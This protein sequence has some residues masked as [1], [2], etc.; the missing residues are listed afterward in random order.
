MAGLTT[1]GF[2][3]KTAA[4]VLAELADA[5]RAS[6]ALGPDWDTSAESPTGQLNGSIATR[7]GSLWELAKLVYDSRDPRAA[8]FAA[9]DSVS[10]LT[11]TAREAA[12]KGTVTLTL[13]VAAGRTIPAG[14][15]AHVVGAPTNRWVTKAA[16]VNST[17]STASVSV[18]AEAEI[19]GAV[20]S[21][22]ASYAANAGTITAIAT[23]V[24]GW[25]SV[26]NASDAVT[27]TAA[28]TDPV[29]RARRDD[30]LY[31]QGSAFD[32][33]R[34]A[35]RA[36]D[37]VVVVTVDENDT[38]TDERYRGG[39]PPHSV[40]AIVQGGTDA[41]VAA[42]LW[43]RRAFGIRSYGTSSAT[44]VD[45]GGATRTLYFT[46]PTTV[47]AYAEVVVEI[48]AA[49]YAGDAALKAAVAAV[50]TGQLAGAPIR[51]SDIIAAARAVAGVTDCTRVRLG[52]ASSSLFEANLLASTR[53]ALSLATARVEVVIA[54]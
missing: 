19:A 17:G 48:D 22:G 51:R 24:T 16:A 14:S 36:V 5:Q 7:L 32:A 15:V 38:D 25:L 53:E 26:T 3:V 23:P 8:R 27:G 29:L 9:L 21:N 39:L 42:A 40:E 54:S 41:A 20:T 12:Q 34:E 46:R 1:T 6:S 43:S 10:A 13:S 2:V 28:E 18:A 31:A 11:G 45:D 35:L 30:E 37:G 4:E 49:T 44:V 50:T 47:N 52:R 33:V